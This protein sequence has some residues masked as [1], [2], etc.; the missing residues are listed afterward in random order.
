MEWTGQSKPAPNGWKP[1]HWQE[2]GE[3]YLMITVVNKLDT[4]LNSTSKIVLD[5]AVS[6][7]SDGAS[8][9]SAAKYGALMLLGGAMVFL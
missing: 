8:Y 1:T 6:D 7:L 9:L 5:I 2:C 3:R 4:F